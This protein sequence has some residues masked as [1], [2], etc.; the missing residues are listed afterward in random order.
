MRATFLFALLSFIAPS[1]HAQGGGDA[2]LRAAKTVIR[3]HAAS[4]LPVG[5]AKGLLITVAKKHH[6]G[7][8]PGVR[9]FT[10]TDGAFSN[11]WRLVGTVKLG[12]SPRV[13]AAHNPS[14][15]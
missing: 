7:D 11:P 2:S 1:A 10:V 5:A 12:K 8:R 14:G 6:S 15:V 9:G 13:L 3:T 4:Y